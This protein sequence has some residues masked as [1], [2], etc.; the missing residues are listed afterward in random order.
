MRDLPVKFFLMVFD[1]LFRLLP[2]GGALFLGKVLGILGYY[3]APGRRWTALR[4]LETALGEEKSHGE[5]RR[6]ARRSFEH[7]GMTAAELFR[8]PSL[9]REGIEDLVSFTGEGILKKCLDEGRGLLL[10]SAHLGNWELIGAALAL[11]GY[12]LAVIT[13]IPKSRAVHRWWTMYREKVGIRV[14]KGRGLLKDGVAH[15]SEGG[16]LGF[17]LDQNARRREGVFVPFFGR[18]ACT[19]KSL[20]LMSRRTGAPVVPVFIFRDGNRHQLVIEEPIHLDATGDVEGDVLRWT[21]A[22][23]A[24]TERVIRLHPE[25]WTW[26]HE[27]WKTK[28]P[29]KE[30]HGDTETRR[31][32]G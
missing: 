12:P 4:N 1:T 19:L 32:G 21:A 15:L 22:Y 24:W 29:E 9:D 3:L 25:Q 14:L 13:K 2:R 7:L 27:R 5:K 31:R 8:I 20:A 10:L 18:E 17:V 6:I 11:R 23:N 30:R 26:L 28:R 16:M